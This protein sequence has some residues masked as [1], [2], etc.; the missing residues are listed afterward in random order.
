MLRKLF[1]FLVI[2]PV[3]FASLTGRFFKYS[4]GSVIVHEKRNIEKKRYGILRRTELLFYLDLTSAYRPPRKFITF[5]FSSSFSFFP[6]STRATTKRF[7]IFFWF[8][9]R[10]CRLRITFHSMKMTAYQM[11]L[12]SNAWSRASVKRSYNVDVLS[13][14]WKTRKKR[15][16]D[17]EKEKSLIIN[18]KSTY[19]YIF[20]ARKYSIRRFV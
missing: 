19:I 17:K 2:L 4:K 20:F 12:F 16:E 7:D 15:K 10:L 9:S 1:H 6:S 5:N 18:L 14:Y 13:I 8:S 11:D 3:S